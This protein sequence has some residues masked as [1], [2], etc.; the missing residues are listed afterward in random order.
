MD[1]RKFILTTAGI[2]SGISV[3]TYST[4]PRLSVA[5]PKPVEKPNIPQP[6]NTNQYFDIPINPFEIQGE[7]L[8]TSS[9]ITIEYEIRR[10]SDD[11]SVVTATESVNVPSSGSFTVNTQGRKLRLR[12]SDI[13]GG[14][15]DFYIHITISH[16]DTG[17]LD[18]QSAG[19]TAKE[20][21]AYF[22]VSITG[23][24]SPVDEG[25]TLTVN[26]EVEN[27]GTESDTQTITMD[28]AGSQRDSRSE[29]VASGDTVTGSLLWNSSSG[30]S[31]DY[32]AI[33]SSSETSDSVSVSVESAT[34]TRSDAIAVADVWYEPTS[35][36]WSKQK[37]GSE[38]PSSIEPDDTQLVSDYYDS[39]LDAVKIQGLSQAQ[40]TVYS[41]TGGSDSISSATVFETDAAGYAGYAFGLRAYTDGYGQYGYADSC[42]SS[43]SLGAA[44]DNNFKCLGGDVTTTTIIFETFNRVDSTPE[45]EIGGDVSGSFTNPDRDT[46]TKEGVSISGFADSNGTTIHQGPIAIAESDTLSSDIKEYFNQNY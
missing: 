29:T 33:V 39:G 38:Y 5:S 13:S 9:D 22:N 1:R 17:S 31:G 34:V 8:S 37:G 26:Y 41:G 18:A 23:S 12:N 4:T 11:S 16:P 27:T 14:S 46:S 42:G 28:V 44:Y 24:S 32:T 45:F 25:N 15:E 10:A 6:L 20:S 43:L 40:S 2:A 35:L 36:G 30:D 7:N 3:Y 21:G 19:F